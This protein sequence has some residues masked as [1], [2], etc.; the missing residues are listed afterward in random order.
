MFICNISLELTSFDSLVNKSPPRRNSNIKYNFPSVWKAARKK[1]EKLINFHTVT[2]ETTRSWLFKNECM[3]EKLWTFF[4]IVKFDN[5]WMVHFSKNVSLH[6]C[7]H[8]VSDYKLELR[9]IIYRF[10]NIIIDAGLTKSTRTLSRK[11]HTSRKVELQILCCHTTKIWKY[12]RLSCTF[13]G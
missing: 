12:D 11:S 2:I 10:L 5:K 4:T 6:F 7:S 1:K 9:E 8:S 13:S 3:K